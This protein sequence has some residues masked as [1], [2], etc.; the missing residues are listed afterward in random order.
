MIGI[1]M[2]EKLIKFGR[3]YKASFCIVFVYAVFSLY[4]LLV[5]VF[6]PAPAENS[7]MEMNVR[8][9]HASNGHPNLT[10]LLD[11]GVKGYLEFPTSSYD[12]I[13]GPGGNTI[14]EEAISTLNQ[15]CT[16][17]VGVD[18]M[19]FLLFRKIIRVWYVECGPV[20]I[21]YSEIRA[22]YKKALGYAYWIDAFIQVF[23][24]FLCGVFIYADRGKK[25]RVSRQL[26]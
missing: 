17:K 18:G 6:N 2:R 25:W 26:R 24:L 4:P 5:V 20:S 1:K 12:L 14:N 15:G 10:V 23:L 16:G 8:I 7:L 19:R 11:G 9:I 13:R 21:S 22:A 3:Q